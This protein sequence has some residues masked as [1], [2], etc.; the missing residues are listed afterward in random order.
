VTQLRWVVS[1]VAAA[2]L[3]LFLIE[4]FT[5][6]RAPVRALLP[7]LA[8]NAALS[9]LA[10]GTS[11]ALIRPTVLSVMGW[12][13]QR[14]V[15]L[16]HLLGLPRPAAAGV[17]FLLMDLSFY[18]WHRANHRLRFLWR[19]HNVHHVDPDLDLSTSFRFHF[20]EVTLSVAFRALQ[21]ALIGVTAPVYAAY[22]LIFQL[23][24][25]FHHSNLRLPIAIERILN[26]VLVTPRMHGIHH[27]QV[28][29]E[30]DSNYSVVFSWWD[31]LH[32]TQR[33]NVPQSR[34]T[35]G[36]PAYSDPED[37]AL[38][39]ALAMP[40]RRQKDYWRRPDGST[41]ERDPALLGAD[42]GRLEE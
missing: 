30:T 33:L 13:A 3:L 5:P 41:S 2:A 36:V 15:G 37:N 10:F 25:M 14:D 8:L 17:A 39:S 11:F 34:I 38:W 21:I 26:L 18:Y 6:L 22:E 42:R 40:F 23:N 29:D 24:T 1:A 27:S 7:R 19:L 31:R 12:S 32:R 4:R 20:G 28:R 9:V 35:I 16:V